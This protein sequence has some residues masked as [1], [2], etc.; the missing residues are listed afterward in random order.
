MRVGIQVSIRDGI[1]LAADR[2]RALGCETTQIF[3][4]NP[5]SWTAKPL[6]AEDAALLRHK[7][8]LYAIR[9]L[10]VHVSYLPNLATPDATLHA[11]S[12]ERVVEEVRRADQ[13]AADYFVI[14]LGHHLG[15]G[16]AAALQSVRRA[17]EAILD[18]SAPRLALLLEN[19]AGGTGS[20]GDRFEHIADL[21]R[22]LHHDPRPGFCFDTAHA[23]A[24]GYDLRTAEAV[25]R[26][27]REIDDRIGLERLRVVHA[28]D[29]MFGLGS[30]RD[31]HQH[32]G[33]GRIGRGGF[34]A[35]AAHPALRDLPF[36]LETP[37]K[38]EGDDA[39]NV[40]ALKRL[41]PS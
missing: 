10:V 34:R 3:S 24:A 23:F 41:R 32:I 17:L 2:A 40:R 26:T 15:A 7:L 36:I 6:D 31:R 38:K 19:T 14:H 39:A 27:V 33:R 21:L 8:R 37:L 22:G 20:V 25:D 30:R 28:N 16:Q 29:A 11:R 4:C 13:L 35:M 5:R 12:V 1:H 18:A 9:P